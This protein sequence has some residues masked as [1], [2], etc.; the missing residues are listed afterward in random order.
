[1]FRNGSLFTALHV[2][3]RDGTFLQFAF[4]DHGHISDALVV[5]ILELLGKLYFIGI[6]LR[7]DTGLAHLAKQTEAM[8]VARLPEIGEEQADIPSD[9]IGEFIRL[10]QYVVDAV[11]T[12]ADA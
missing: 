9:S 1:H 6:E 4:P 3:D 2:L 11:G 7:R 8:S 10:L 5:G 12:K